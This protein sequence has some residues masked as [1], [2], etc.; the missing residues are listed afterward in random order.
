MNNEKQIKQFNFDEIASTYDTHVREQLPF[1]DFLIQMLVFLGRA[2]IQPATIVYDIGAGTGNLSVQLELICD[3]RGSNLLCIEK[4]IPMTEIL[5]KRLKFAIP[6]A[7]AIG[8]KYAPF[9]FAVVNL[10]M[11][12]F[13]VTERRVFIETLIDNCKPG[14]IIVIVDKF[15]LPTSY[16]GT[17]LRRMPFD[18]KISNG[19]TPVQIITKEIGLTGY[20]RPLEFNTFTEHGFRSF[21][22]AGEFAGLVY[23]KPE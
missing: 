9:S 20:Q 22:Q 13:P 8:F 12:F 16:L 10:V 4:S 23:E 17:V 5:S 3:S 7:D 11:M 15:I 14:G 18:W 6:H 1:Y 2:Y 19:S 21:F